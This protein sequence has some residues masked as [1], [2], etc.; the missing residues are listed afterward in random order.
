MTLHRYPT[1]PTPHSM[2]LNGFTKNIGR[3]RLIEGIRKL[4]QILFLHT[5]KTLS[6]TH[7]LLCHCKIL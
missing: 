5:Q 2:C 7:C 1:P 6:Q 4:V 3:T